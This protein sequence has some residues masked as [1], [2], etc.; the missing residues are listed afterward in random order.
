MFSWGKLLTVLKDLAANRS[1]KF[2]D[3][4]GAKELINHYDDIWSSLAPL[5]SSLKAAAKREKMEKDEL[6]AEEKRA[7]RER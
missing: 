2:P 3:Y 5:R 6:E 7:M 4:T 1:L